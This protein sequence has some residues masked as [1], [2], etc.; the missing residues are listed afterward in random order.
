[1]KLAKDI[2]AVHEVLAGIVHLRLAV[3][4]RENRG[5]VRASGHR[6]SNLAEGIVVQGYNDMGFE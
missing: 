1:M 2:P 5:D 4:S 3:H 6:Q